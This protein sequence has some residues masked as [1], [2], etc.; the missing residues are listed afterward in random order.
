MYKDKHIIFV[1]FISNVSQAMCIKWFHIT[2]TI[3][4]VCIN[5]FV[6]FFFT[7]TMHLDIIKVFFSFTN[8][9]TSELS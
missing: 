3:Y 5:T 9:C 2:V 7:H 4:L 8:R 1:R 6:S